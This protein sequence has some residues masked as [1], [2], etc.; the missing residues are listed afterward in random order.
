MEKINALKE[1]EL[2]FYRVSN[3]SYLFSLELLKNVLIMNNMK[4]SEFMKICYRL[5]GLYMLKLLFKKI[6]LKNNF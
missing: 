1:I 2:L 4:Y 6:S 5:K 3:R